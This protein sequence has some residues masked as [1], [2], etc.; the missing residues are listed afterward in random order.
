MYRLLKINKLFYPTF[1]FM[2][3]ITSLKNIAKPTLIRKKAE[4]IS[5]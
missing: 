4:F 3:K 2:H 1:Y 5:I